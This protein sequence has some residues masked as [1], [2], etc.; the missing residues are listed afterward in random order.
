MSSKNTI[1]AP[2][3]PWLFLA[4]ITLLTLKYTAYPTIPWW[5]ISLPIICPITILGIFF[6]IAVV[7]AVLSDDIK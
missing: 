2:T 6:G 7:V 4:F 3:A 1:V 5:L